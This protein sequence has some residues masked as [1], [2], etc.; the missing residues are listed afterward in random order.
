MG[1]PFVY[2]SEWQVLLCTSCGY[3]LRP[4]REVWVR[5]LRQAPHLLRGASLKALVELF[6]SY[7]LR[8]AEAEPG[9]LPTEAISGL[10]LLDGFQCLTCAAHLTRD[11][12]AMQRHVS[13][14]HQQKPAVHEKSPLWR[15]CKLQTF[16]AENRW[17]RYFI[18]DGATEAVD[19]GTKSLDSGEADFFGQLDKDAA[20]AEEDAKAEANI[21]HGFDRHRSAVVP[22]LIRTGIEEHTRGLK[23]DEMHA[24]F[25]VPKTTESEPELFLMLEVM[26]EIFT[27][28]HS[29]CFDGPDCMLTW[30]R[31]LALS[32]FHTAAVG[33][34]RGFDPKK[35]PNTLKTNFGYWKQFLTYSYRVA[36]RGSHFT[37]ADD[38]QRTPESCIQLTD[39]QEKAWEAATQSAVEQDRPALRDAMLALSMAL[40]CHE[41]GG[42]RYSSPLLSF[43]AILS[44]KPHT[45]T[46][47]EAG[48]Y[49]SCL[50]GVI[51]VVQ[52]IIFHTSARLEKA[53]LGSTLEHI[54][55]Y[56]GQF[57]KQDT[58][59]PMGEI[60]GWCLLLFTVSKEVVG[61]HQAQWD[62]DEKVLTYGDIDLHMDHVPRLLL[63]E[64]Q[65]AQHLLYNELIF[66]AQT[67]PRICA[68]TLKDNLDADAF[69][70]FFG[71][72]RENVELLK[73]L[74][75]SLLAVIQ[76]SKPLR[77]SFLDTTADGAKVWREKAIERYEAVADEFLKRLLVLIHM[78][79]GQPLRESELFSVTW[80][81]SQRR[82]N[83]Y[84][85]H[86]LVM[87]HTTYHKGQQQTGKFK[88][89]IRFLPVPFGELLLDYLVVIIPLRQVFLRQSAPHAVISP[90]LWWKDG[91]VWTDNRL[92]R[93]IEQACTRASIPRLH[94]ANWRQMTVNIVKTKFVADVGC[95]EVDDGAGDEDAEEIEADIRVMTK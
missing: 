42:S 18:V 88:D 25:A 89:N 31:Q 17:V 38:D 26:D 90:Y 83:V 56:C 35:E 4:G 86:G 60:L 40:I 5:H 11:C 75:R 87:L 72:Y 28:A 73:P 50:S 1:D 71:Q 22:W 12:K 68:W 76:D 7:A 34:A 63:S 20:V 61:L 16:F 64:F 94:I 70:W 9:R 65:Q 57:L 67:L 33:K 92:T 46:W 45:K 37:T 27:E 79:S 52:L 10:R 78:G 32:R 43:C 14:A 81:N 3:C 91:K 39:A 54:K 55:Q 53:E 47:K 23:K 51:W 48:N 80:R 84:L 6:A 66:G 44:V 49:N 13:K 62:V 58:E 2:L 69:G 36:Y 85:K 30:P 41:F 24:S 95:F 74:T 21:V 29:W 82:R 93:C 19:A 59:T 8:A 77:D 15:E